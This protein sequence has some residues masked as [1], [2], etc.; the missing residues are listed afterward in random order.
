MLDQTL[1][2][3][4]ACLMI[5]HKNYIQKLHKRADMSQWIQGKFDFSQ[6]GFEM[7]LARNRIEDGPLSK[8]RERTLVECMDIVSD[9]HN[10]HLCCR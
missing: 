2:N 5:S 7:R 9:T 8:G 10:N 1:S 3:L 6:N 4:T